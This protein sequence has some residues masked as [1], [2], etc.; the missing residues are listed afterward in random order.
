[1]ILEEKIL[2]CPYC[3]K[4][5]PKYDSVYHLVGCLKSLNTTPIK[6]YVLFKVL[7][8]YICWECQTTCDARVRRL[9]THT[10]SDNRK[11]GY[12]IMI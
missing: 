6:R 5:Y 12:C 9:L 3:A 8:V 7:R 1:M 11:I 2:Q 4:Y 10:L